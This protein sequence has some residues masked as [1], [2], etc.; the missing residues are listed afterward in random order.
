[1]DANAGCREL[2][3]ALEEVWGLRPDRTGKG[4]A[5]T[6]VTKVQP[7]DGFVMELPDGTVWS[8]VAWK[9]KVV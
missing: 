4:S 3:Q 8:V 1:M 7:P 6:I 9:Q 5:R 2:L